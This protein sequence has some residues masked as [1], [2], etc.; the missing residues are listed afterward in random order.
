MK[1]VRKKIPGVHFL[2]Y[3]KERIC[4]FAPESHAIAQLDKTNFRTAVDYLLIGTDS[5]TR[6]A[7][8]IED[9][10][11]QHGVPI[12]YAMRVTDYEAQANLIATTNVGIGFVFESVARRFSVN[13]PVKII[14]L[15]E[16]WA[17]LDL[18]MCVRDVKNKSESTKAFAKLVRQRFKHV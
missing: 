11:L 18:V 3:R 16:T 2:P 5:T 4:I 7:A 15:T 13:F 10:A 6:L 1:I 12:K 9:A 8:I 17:E 14:S